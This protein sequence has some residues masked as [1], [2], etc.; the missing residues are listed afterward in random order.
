MLR[1][2]LLL[3]YPQLLAEG[4]ELGQGGATVESVRGLA[5][6]R[7]AVVEIGHLLRESLK[8]PPLYHAAAA[9]SGAVLPT[10]FLSRILRM[11]IE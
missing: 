4:L 11:L 2:Q 8:F 3:G 6:P 5:Q 10:E 9:Y 7:Q 1:A